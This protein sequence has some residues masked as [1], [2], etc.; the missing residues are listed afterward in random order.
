M[1]TNRIKQIK[2]NLRFTD[3][4]TTVRSSD[5]EKTLKLPFS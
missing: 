2:N 5:F 4:V 3:D 1:I